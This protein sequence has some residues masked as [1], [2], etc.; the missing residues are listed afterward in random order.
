MSPIKTLII[1]GQ[2]NHD[3]QRSTPYIWLL[4]QNSGRFD[5][6]VTTSP[7]LALAEASA[8]DP[9]D[10]IISD[11]NGTLWSDKV[12]VNFEKTIEQ[13]TGLVILHAA[14][15]SFDGWDAYER[16]VGLLWRQGTG[17][18]KFHEFPVT[19]TDHQHPITRGLS[20]FRTTDELYHRLVHLH[21]VDY[22]VLST[23]FSSEESGGTGGDEPMM[24]V[25]Q[26]G[27]GRVFHQV[28]GHVWSGGDL[29]ALENEGFR[30][31]FIRGC[32][33][34]ATGDVEDNR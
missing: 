6:D 16:M 24:V 23:A 26:Y 21:H 33:W 30:T 32:E 3:W 7:D 25:T 22:H 19:I 17:H 14:D 5:V 27:E 29:T 34:A 13:G 28:L 12:K 2:N 1:S 20:D 9:F 31:S 8:L 18:G 15:N 11:Y 4:L 10:L